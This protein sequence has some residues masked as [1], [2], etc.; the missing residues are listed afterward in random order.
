M[1]FLQDGD[2]VM[3]IEIEKIELDGMLL[4]HANAAI[5]ERGY[6]PR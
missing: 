3:G 5:D 6:Y 1:L 4:L 2:I